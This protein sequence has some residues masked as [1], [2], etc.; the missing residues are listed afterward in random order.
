MTMSTEGFHLVTFSTKHHSLSKNTGRVVVRPLT[1]SFLLHSSLSKDAPSPRHPDSYTLKDRNPFDVHVYYNTSEERLEAIILRDEM[2]QNFPW[3]RFYNLK[4][5]PIGPHPLPMWEAD[6]G[7]YQNRHRWDE[8][9]KFIERQHG[10][11]SILIHPHSTDG[12]YADHTKYAFW[13][14]EVL[15]LRIRGW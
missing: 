4:E 11:L 15:K 1:S 14:G 7:G 8:V 2:Q 6:F 5:R 3:M 10:N 12:D 13:V 9:R